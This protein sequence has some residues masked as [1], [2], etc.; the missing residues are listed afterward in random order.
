MEHGGTHGWTSTSVDAVRT[1]LEQLRTAVDEMQA[2]QPS[3]L[4]AD[5]LELL[6]TEGRRELERAEATWSRAVEHF[7][8][9]AWW[10]QQ[11]MSMKSW[12][13]TRCNMAPATAAVRLRSARRLRDLP[14]VADAYLKGQL[15]TAHVTTITR[16]VTNDRVEA[17]QAAEDVL[18]EAGKVLDPSELAKVVAHWRAMVDPD[19]TRDDHQD[20]EDRRRLS[21]SGVGDGTAMDGWWG[22]LGAEVIQQAIRAEMAR[23]RT[24]DDPRRPEQLRADALRSICQQHL[25]Q[26]GLPRRRGLLH[27]V[28]VTVSW[29]TLTGTA[30]DPAWL[31]H[32]GPVPAETARRLAC[33]ADVSRILLGPRGEPLDVGRRCRTVTPAIWKALVIRD[34]GCVYPGCDAPLAWLE[35]HHLVHWAHDG[36]TSLDNMV[37]L[38]GE[39]HHAEHEGGCTLAHDIPTRRWV[40]HTPDGD[41]IVAGPT[42]RDHIPRLAGISAGSDPPARARMG[43]A[44]EVRGRY[45]ST[46]P[47]DPRQGRHRP[48]STSRREPAGHPCTPA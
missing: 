9:R 48:R 21:V 33:D 44:S 34:G 2:M 30:N 27:A 24:T 11:A 38:C 29:E 6:I 13:R 10:K 37:L 32:G 47:R 22:G 18:V 12:L 5:A 16:A 14:Q 4:D 8:R 3:D 35:A 20:A 39:H 19:G 17:A 42:A 43:V 28:N 23:L 1:R 26:R 25:Q 31:E 40:V 7:D 15:S 41:R 46:G 45:D 36:P